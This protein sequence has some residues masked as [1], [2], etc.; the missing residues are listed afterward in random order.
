MKKIEAIIRREMLEPVRQAVA[1]TGYPGMTVTEVRG[2]G[3]QKGIAHHWRGREY[4]VEFLPKVKIEIV[5][6]DRDLGKILS[7]V[8]RKAR[9]GETG[10]G[11]VFVTNIESA[12]RIR[13]GEAGED[14]I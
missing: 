6:L 9:T 8:V 1:E 10:D 14:A 12:V 13:T 7:A 3:K 2:H 4:R 11:K 5:V